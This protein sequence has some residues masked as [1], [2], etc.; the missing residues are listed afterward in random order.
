[1]WPREVADPQDTAKRLHAAV[2]PTNLQQL[3]QEEIEALG[4][5]FRRQL[6][7]YDSEGNSVLAETDVDYDPWQ[8]AY[9]MLGGFIDCD[10]QTSGGRNSHDSGSGDGADDGCGRWMMWAA[11]VDPNY[12]GGGRDEYFGDDATSPLDCHNPETNWQLLGVYRQEFYQFIEQISKHLWYITD[13]DYITAIAGLAYMTDSDCF[14]VAGGDDDAAENIYAG[15]QPLEEGNFQMSLYLDSQCLYPADDELG[16]TYD[17][18]GYASDNDDGYGY[19]AAAQEYTF[20]NLNKVYEP[21][22]YCTPCMDYPTYQDGYF[23]GDSGTDDDDL[24]NQCWKFH[25]HD[26]YTCESSCVELGHRQGTIVSV[27]YGDTMFGQVLEDFL[28]SASNQMAMDESDEETASS[29]EPES[30]MSKL[31]ANTFLTFAG[32]VF[33]AT[34]L[35]F[36]VARRSSRTERNSSR[37]R[38][39]LEDHVS[40][41][42]TSRSKKK[43]KRGASVADTSRRSK[44][45]TDTSRRS[46]S[47]SSR[48][49]KESKYEPPSVEEVERRPRKRSSSRR[50]HE[51]DDF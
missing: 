9:R 45:R 37:S 43:S 31:K 22:K 41:S 1:M 14:Q 30:K 46:K 40:G 3:S 12:Q 34:F 10:H 32:I 27:K 4:D 47:K 6:Q 15:V 48:K 50:R 33:I 8:Q 38:R 28:Y 20:E 24:I 19:W 35:A 13:Y 23:I 25:S 21:F 18:F 44:S 11:Y 7:T 2:R 42:G 36:A 17:D 51:D 16:M 39:L 29:N 5:D 26:S 49:K